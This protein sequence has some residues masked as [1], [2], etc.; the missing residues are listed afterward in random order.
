MTELQ[1]EV[2]QLLFPETLILSEYLGWPTI[3]LPT[4]LVPV[5]Y[6]YS[7]A[8]RL[9]KAR[10]GFEDLFTRETLGESYN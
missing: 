8:P 3:S 4:N 10:L 1:N 7:R 6:L 2:R 5:P 9:E